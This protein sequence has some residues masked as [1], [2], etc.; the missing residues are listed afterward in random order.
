VEAGQLVDGHDARLWD[1]SVPGWP[2]GQAGQDQLR[3]CGVAQFDGFLPPAA[4]T[5]MVAL[6]SELATRAWASDQTH[7]AYFEPPDASADPSHPRAFLQR[8]AKKAIAY[9]QIPAAAPIRRLY[10]SHKTRYTA[11]VTGSGTLAGIS[12]K[13]IVNGSEGWYCYVASGSIRKC[14]GNTEY[15]EGEFVGC[16]PHDRLSYLA[17]DLGYFPRVEPGCAR[18]IGT[19]TELGDPSLWSSHQPCLRLFRAVARGPA[20]AGRPGPVAAA[21]ALLQGR[22]VVP[23]TGR[24]A[25]PGVPRRAQAH[26]VG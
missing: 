24:R 2:C 18:A 11:G 21:P 25:G 8:S 3:E 7:T 16:I 9:D 14:S 1:S 17:S 19:G 6:T 26:A 23:R 22:G 5:E 15:A 4:V 13:E 12:Y 20:T 10:T